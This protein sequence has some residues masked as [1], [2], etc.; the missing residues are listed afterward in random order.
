MSRRNRIPTHRSSRQRPLPPVYG[1]LAVL[2][3]LAVLLAACEL[4][5][6]PGAIRIT[7]TPARTD[8]PPT[9]GPPT[10]TPTADY[11]A[12]YNPLTG[13]TVDDPS[14][15]QR[16]PLAAKISN[17]PDIVRPQAG[18]SE[19]DM[20]FEHYVEGSLTRFTAIFWT[21]TP[22][23]VGSIRSARLID[24][25]IPSMYGTL[26]VYSGASEP[27]RQRIA[28]LPFAPRAFEGV[29]VGQPLY[30]R[31][32]EIE[33]PHNLFA[34]PS[35]VWA[36][37]QTMGINT[38]PVINDIAFDPAPPDNNTHVDSITVDYGP[39]RV[40]WQY[41]P[42]TG[43]YARFVD[44]EPHR[45]ANNNAQVT[46]ANVV[47][48][49]AYH[50]PDLGIVESEWQGNKSFSTEIQIWTLG[51]VRVFRDG[52]ESDGWWM[53]WEEDVPLTF[54]RDEDGT[55]PLPLKPGNTWFEVVPLDF[56]DVA[57]G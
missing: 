3:S 40:E 23:R 48:V 49:Y 38:P 10:P 47:V 8:E 24:L 42:D 46:A 28:A 29:T 55:L 20:V 4:P 50:Q 41:D 31:D 35:E 17:A 6:T 2:L 15:L 34:V 56:E 52:K 13:L 7:A 54:W 11:P 12:A 57:T 25:E 43:R 1:V 39:D 33:V 53:R 5:D 18:I 9:A 32:P 16:R 37:A 51:P 19:A 45:D 44:G 30:F 22:P 14:V 27:I 21:H 26:L 36:R